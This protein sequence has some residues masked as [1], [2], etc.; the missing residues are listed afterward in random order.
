MEGVVT[1]KDLLALKEQ[2]DAF[3][4]EIMTTFFTSGQR[5]VR[6]VRDIERKALIQIRN[7]MTNNLEKHYRMEGYWEMLEG[8]GTGRRGNLRFIRTETPRSYKGF[9]IFVS[10]G[11]SPVLKYKY[12]V[13]IRLEDIVG[14]A[15]KADKLDY[16]Q[17]WYQDC[18]THPRLMS[19]ENAYNHYKAYETW[20]TKA[21]RIGPRPH[22]LMTRSGKLKRGVNNY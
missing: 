4:Q 11:L 12:R 18:M 16:E 19:I 9:P 7:P 15:N 6:F 22:P 1:Y 17:W 20:A 10:E 3:Q 13:Y 21:R 2:R 8:G 14:W 5:V